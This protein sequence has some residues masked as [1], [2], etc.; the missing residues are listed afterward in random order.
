MRSARCR[1]TTLLN[2]TA[3]GV[4]VCAWLVGRE[5][6]ALR[7]LG[8]FSGNPGFFIELAQPILFM[9]MSD[10]KFDH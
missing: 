4:G 9:S 2:G 3:G 6:Q 5:I 10:L 1:S 7:T 8:G